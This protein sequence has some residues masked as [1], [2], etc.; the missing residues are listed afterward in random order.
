MRQ[1]WVLVDYFYDQLGTMER[2]GI[3]LKDDIGQMVYGMD[4]DRE[5]DKDEQIV[6]LPESSHDVLRRATTPAH[7]PSN[8]PR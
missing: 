8:S 3:S 1:G 7:R 5:R 6:F 2:D 4:V